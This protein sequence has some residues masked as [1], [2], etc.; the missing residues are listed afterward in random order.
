MSMISW[1][2]KY[3]IW[4]ALVGL[5]YYL[6]ITVGVDKI[7]LIK[8]QLPKIASTKFRNWISIYETEAQTNQ[9]S[10]VADRGLSSHPWSKF[11]PLR[12]SISVLQL[13]LL[14][15][16]LLCV[17][18]SS[19]HRQFVAKMNQIAPNCV[20]NFKIFPGW[21]PRAPFQFSASRLDSW[22]SATRSSPTESI[23]FGQ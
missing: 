7:A 22:R 4:Y 20:S 23:L 9:H 19:S 13:L 17:S 14:C 21:H 8:K 1:L 2:R 18:C 16:E 3:W 11:T 12:G 6:T 5:Q 15:C 10:K